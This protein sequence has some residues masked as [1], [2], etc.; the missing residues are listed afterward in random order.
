MKRRFTPRVCEHKVPLG[1]THTKPPERFGS[2]DRH[3]WYRCPK[4]DLAFAGGALEMRRC[5]HVCR[6]DQ[7]HKHPNAKFPHVFT[8]PQKDDPEFPAQLQDQQ[9]IRSL[10]KLRGTILEH[11]AVFVA[12]M[13][14]SLN[15]AAKKDLIDFIC[16]MI[17][18]GQT[19]VAESVNIEEAIGHFSRRVLTEKLLAL[20]ARLKERDFETAR[21]IR[22]VNV[23]V[24]AGTVLGRS[25]IHCLLTNP[26]SENFPI[27]L[28]ICDNDGFDKW[29]YKQL[30]GLLTSKCK[31]HDLIVCSIITDGLKAQRSALQELIHESED[32][33]VMVIVP[34]HCLAHVTQLVFVKSLK[35]SAYL[36]TL[37]REIASLATLLRK[38]RVTR[39]L[40]EK[41]PAPC[42]TRWLYIVDILLWMFRR[43]EKL[44]TFL[45]ASDNNT[46]E[47]SEL[48]VQWKRLLLILM[49]LKRLS[50]CVESSQCALWEVIPLVDAAFAAWKKV[51]PLLSDGEREALRLIALNL[52]RRLSVTS[53]DSVVAC[54]ALSELGRHHLRAREEGL[55]TRGDVHEFMVTE[56]ISSF[57]S[58]FDDP[59]AEM[60]KLLTS[61]YDSS[62]D[63]EDD[64]EPESSTEEDG[65][66][67]A[68][69]PGEDLE[70]EEDEPDEAHDS[71]L[72]DELRPEDIDSVLSY[73]IYNFCFAKACQELCRIGKI[74]G[75]DEQY[76]YRMF[77]SWVFDDRNQT[78]TKWQ[79]GFTPNDIWRQVPA[80]CEEWRS[81]AELAVRLVTI[82]TSEADCERMLSKQKDIQ[83]IRT[84]NIRVELLE[85]RLRT[86]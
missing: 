1:W 40:G 78:P 64:E 34:L 80:N 45:L 19:M 30:F 15:R 55:Q 49:P 2:S 21:E 59:N 7:I 44:D 42:S 82:G 54:F 68:P 71:Q 51:L 37:V 33:N 3:S 50:L 17:R 83:G 16:A 18:I 32:C 4:I 5:S 24:D 27:I 13:G 57:Q 73:D 20:G 79:I 69:V 31:H 9:Q 12:K 75:L 28:E 46:S 74:L 72:G 63:L 58:L 36:R 52:I 77:R 67:V 14:I 53:M 62:T 48:P 6:K 35:D 84:N 25:V 70:E 81:F 61:S 22:F 11:T 43:Q 60:T 85:A 10:E 8:I 76:V 56:R 41:C 23:A 47:L 39:E 38:R 65:N 86:E 26:Y 29:K 66:E